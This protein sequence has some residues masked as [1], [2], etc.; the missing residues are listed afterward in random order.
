[1]ANT[2]PLRYC[3]ILRQGLG[4]K[5][6]APGGVSC[7]RSEWKAVLA[8]VRAESILPSGWRIAGRDTGMVLVENLLLAMRFSV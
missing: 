5:A 6:R 7:L 8:A 3:P 1:M 4:N 2:W